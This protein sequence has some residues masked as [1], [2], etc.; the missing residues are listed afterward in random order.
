MS[1]NHHQEENIHHS[2]TELQVLTPK[3]IAVGITMKRTDSKH[4]R[5]SVDE[6]APLDVMSVQD[7]LLKQQDIIQHHKRVNA[8]E[9]PADT[10]KPANYQILLTQP[11]SFSENET[12]DATEK[13]TQMIKALGSAC[14]YT[15]PHQ[16]TGFL[17]T[18]IN[19]MEGDQDAFNSLPKQVRKTV[20][21]CVDQEKIAELYHKIGDAIDATHLN[22]KDESLV[23]ARETLKSTLDKANDAISPKIRD[24][25]VDKQVMLIVKPDNM[26]TLQPELNEGTTSG[27]ARAVFNPETRQNYIEISENK[28][29]DVQYI[30]N[31]L[32]STAL[33]DIPVLVT[34]D[35]YKNMISELKALASH[36]KA[37]VKLPLADTP[38]SKGNGMLKEVFVRYHDQACKHFGDDQVKKHCPTLSRL[39]QKIDALLE[40]KDNQNT[41]QTPEE[42]FDITQ[43]NTQWVEFG[44]TPREQRADAYKPRTKV[45]ESLEADHPVRIFAETIDARYPPAK[46]LADALLQEAIEPAIKGE[47]EQKIAEYPLKKLKKTWASAEADPEHNDITTNSQYNRLQHAMDTLKE[48]MPDLAALATETGHHKTDQSKSHVDKLQESRQKNTQTVARV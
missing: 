37:T 11:I 24:Y 38:P 44:D 14:G 48:A 5:F 34:N 27:E 13:A 6:T 3:D 12:L 9:I 31:V 21:Q 23:D 30:T 39:A 10:N 36:Q 4:V 7:V 18:V 33:H 46:N 35:M 45:L 32:K 43:K 20:E 28:V 17:Q 42:R 22:I 40:G 2:L 8:G 47:K 25:L 19:W 41:V 26:R 29:A 15:T 16:Q 1:E